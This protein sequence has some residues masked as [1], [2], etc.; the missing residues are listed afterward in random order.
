MNQ[1][2]SKVVISHHHPVAASLKRYLIGFILSL[3]LTSLAYILAVRHN[4]TMYWLGGTVLGLALLQFVIQL[5]CF[6]HLGTETK[7]R[8]KLA[9]FWLMILVV[10]ILIIGSLWIMAGL[11]YRMSPSQVNQYLRGQDSL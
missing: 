7:P 5:I 9:V 1:E 6:L 3:Y 2:H 4:L 11:N 10:G 8:W